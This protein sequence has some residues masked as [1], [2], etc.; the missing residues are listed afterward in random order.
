MDKESE[1][2]LNN[3]G[4]YKSVS[5]WGIVRT[6]PDVARPVMSCQKHTTRVLMVVEL[7]A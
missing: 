2:P 5:N 3:Q 6:Q 7:V 1:T 4:N